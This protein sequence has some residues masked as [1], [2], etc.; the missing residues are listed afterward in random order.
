MSQ[1]GIVLGV[2]AGNLAVLLNV[3]MLRETT[4]RSSYTGRSVALP[5]QLEQQQMVEVTPP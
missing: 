2:D 5:E 3:G 4:T 1:Y